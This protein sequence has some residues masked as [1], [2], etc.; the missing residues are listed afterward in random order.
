M[1]DQT[2]DIKTVEEAEFVLA[3]LAGAI[4]WIAAGTNEGNHVASGDT[5]DGLRMAMRLVRAHR[6][7][8]AKDNGK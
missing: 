2:K 7:E 3:S 5:R 4:G 8:L 1:I 6:N